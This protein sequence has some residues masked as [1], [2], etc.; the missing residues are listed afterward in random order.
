MLIILLEIR[1]SRL[2]RHVL[3]RS[4]VFIMS[5]LVSCDAAAYYVT[6]YCIRGCQKLFR[7]LL[8]SPSLSLSLLFCINK[9][10]TLFQAAPPARAA[11]VD[12]SRLETISF[13]EP[14]RHPSRGKSPY[15]LITSPE[16]N[17][18]SSRRGCVPDVH[19]YAYIF[20]RA[21]VARKARGIPRGSRSTLQ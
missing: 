4:R 6:R 20:A 8:N 21:R 5:R 10:R 2:R 9:E 16:E 12:P 13:G 1:R 3:A 11:R 7:R 19:V 15:T 18:V 17:A 14:Y